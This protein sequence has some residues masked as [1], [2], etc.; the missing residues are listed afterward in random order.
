MGKYY[1]LAVVVGVALLLS[2]G[3]CNV[4][5]KGVDG[6][7]GQAG[8]KGRDGLPGQK[9]A[10]GEPA[11]MDNNVVDAATLVTLRGNIGTRGPQGPM[12]PKGYRGVLGAPGN[13][14]PPGQPGPD[15][16]SIN[17]NDGS[18]QQGKVAFSVIRTTSTYPPYN[19]ALTYQETAVN[20][21]A[22]GHFDL[23]NGYFTCREPGV[24]YFVFHAVAKASMCLRIASEA[25]GQDKV[26]FCNYNKNVDQVLSGS[27]VLQLTATQRVWL[28]SFY[29]MQTDTD[30]R[31]NRD[32]KIIFSGFLIFPNSD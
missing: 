27:T 23:G 5:C 7:P 19:K 14:G 2:T 21:P 15:G 24:Y 16:Q 12:G 1:G 9:G 8:G 13:P 18:S 28:E 4:N 30:R 17:H 32:K 3:Q 25:L 11:L 26:G 29:D 20:T 22:P 6:H 10:K 31:D